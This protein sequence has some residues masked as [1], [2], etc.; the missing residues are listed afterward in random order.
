MPKPQEL[1]DGELILDKLEPGRHIGEG[2]R[3]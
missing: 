2:Q 1:K 3:S